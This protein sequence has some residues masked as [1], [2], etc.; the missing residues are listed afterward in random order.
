MAA[1]VATVA[2]FF[3]WRTAVL[4]T[5]TTGLAGDASIVDAFGRGLLAWSAHL[6]D[7]VMFGARSGILLALVLVAYFV[8]E[9][10]RLTRPRRRSNGLASARADVVVCG[11]CFFVLPAILQAPIAAMN[12]TALHADAS[13]V[14]AAMQSRLYYFSI[15]GLAILFAAGVGRVGS[16]TKVP[17]AA[18]LAMLAACVAAFG[19]VAHDTA[20]AFARTTAASRPMSE[21]ISAAI[22]HAAPA[23]AAPCRIV[24][25]GVQPPPEWN[26]YVSVDSVAK[27]LTADVERV[28]RCVVESDYVTYFNLMRGDANPADAS[29]YTARS[30][31]GQP[32]PWLRVGAMTSAYLDP[33]AG[34]DAATL[35]GIVFL[36]YENGVFADVTDDVAS[37]RLPVTLR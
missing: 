22:D 7:Y 31:R 9:F 19:W 8:L 32:I 11:L 24:V 34:I 10:E 5:L 1:L 14:E 30:A 12:A 6:L 18:L 28:G 35:A 33:P 15:G 27:A 16:S 29:P 17:H 25:L 2:L 20:T 26:I 3:A 21:R 13:A 36:R 23:G 37:G 4:G